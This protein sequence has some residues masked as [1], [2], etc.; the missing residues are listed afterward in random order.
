MNIISGP[1]IINVPGDVWDQVVEFYKV[2]LGPFTS[3][4]GTVAIWQQGTF[5]L[6]LIR[7]NNVALTGEPNA[8][9][10]WPS[11]PKAGNTLNISP[12]YPNEQGQSLYTITLVSLKT[13][14]TLFPQSKIEFGVIYNPPY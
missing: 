13:S 4:D 9:V 7:N 8:F 6:Q 5:K 3:N 12:V 11:P 2:Q 14:S 10:G 1:G